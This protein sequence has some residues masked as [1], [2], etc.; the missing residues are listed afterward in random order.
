[1]ILPPDEYEPGGVR[2][3]WQHEA[4]S[5]TEEVFRDDIFDNLSDRDRALISSQAGP[6][7]GVALRAAHEPPHH[8]R[9]SFVP[10]RCGRAIDIFGHHHAT[11]SRAGVLGRRGF[12]LESAVARICREAG[13]QVAVNTFLRDVDLPVLAKQ[14]IG[15]QLAI[16]TTLVCAMHCDG[17]P[18]Q[19]AAERD[20]V[21]SQQPAGGKNVGTQSWWDLAAERVWWFWRWKL[22]AGGHPR[23]GPSL[24]IWPRHGLVERYHSSGNASNRLGV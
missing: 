4:A 14:T 17:S 11:C 22:E 24:R 12:A 2:Q 3:G 15:C 23:Q 5:R 16:D 19:G 1:M 21:V 6:G 18:H 13:G 8:D 7:A 10:C 9:A 20:G